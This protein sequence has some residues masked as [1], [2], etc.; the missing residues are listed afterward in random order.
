[1][2]KTRNAR[3]TKKGLSDICTFVDQNND[4]LKIATIE[5]LKKLSATKMFADYTEQTHLAVNLL[6]QF[7]ELLDEG[8]EPEDIKNNDTPIALLSK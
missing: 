5:A 7:L 6:T 1:M 3:L 2:S 8:A 4:I